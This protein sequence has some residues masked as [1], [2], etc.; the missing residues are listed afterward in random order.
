MISQSTGVHGGGR[1]KIQEKGVMEEVMRDE[2]Q[3]TCREVLKVENVSSSEMEKERG[4]KP[5]YMCNFLT[6]ELSLLF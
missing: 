3:K 5:A 4:G 6:L 1:Q 2:A